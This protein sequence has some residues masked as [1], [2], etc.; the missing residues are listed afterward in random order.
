MKETYRKP[1]KRCYSHDGANYPP[2]VMLHFIKIS[3]IRYSL[4]GVDRIVGIR[5]FHEFDAA[6]DGTVVCRSVSTSVNSKSFRFKLHS[7]SRSFIK[8]VLDSTDISKG[9]FLI[10]EQNNAF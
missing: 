5:S 9:K 4:P 3:D 10:I 7:D 2:K 6:S 1:F 8:R